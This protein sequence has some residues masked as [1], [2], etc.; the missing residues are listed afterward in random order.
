MVG[1]NDL[2]TRLRSDRERRRRIKGKEKEEHV[3]TLA[4]DNA[5][6]HQLAWGG[7]NK[8]SALPKEDVL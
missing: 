5:L 2:T 3:G 6:Q 8:H 4:C 1:V 7:Q